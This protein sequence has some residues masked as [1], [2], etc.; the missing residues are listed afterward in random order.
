[1][2]SSVVVG[3]SVYRLVEA[4]DPP[5]TD[6]DVPDEAAPE[7]EDTGKEMVKE[8]REGPAENWKKFLQPIIINIRNKYGL[9]VGQVRLVGP[10]VKTKLTTPRYGFSIQGHVKFL[11]EAPDD[12]VKKHGLPPYAFEAA[13]T[14]DGELISSVK[15]SGSEG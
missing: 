14:P 1:M 8:L 13:V 15:M 11:P 5:E 2:K 4:Q 6:E 7:E 9:E 3:N 10:R 12:V